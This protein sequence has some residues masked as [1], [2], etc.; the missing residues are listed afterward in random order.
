MNIVAGG[1]GSGQGLSSSQES[2]RNRVAGGGG[3]GSGLSS[4]QESKTEIRTTTVLFVEFSKG[5]TMQKKLRE[6]LDRITP[7]LGFRI[8][9]TEKGGTPLGSLLSNKNL[10]SGVECGRGTCR[11]CAQPDER[12][13]P[14]TLRNVVYESECRVCNPPGTRKEADKQGLEERRALA[15]LYVGESA[16][17][18][19]ERAAEHWRDAESGKEESHMLEHQ[20]ESH[21]GEGPPQFA[22]TVV[23][24]CKTSLERQVREAIR[25]Q[26]RGTVLNK[27]GVYNRCKQTR[28]EAKGDRGG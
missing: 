15:S 26:M 25:I 8:R 22:F 18:V 20:V 23:K 21:E 19:A 13:E 7:M 4:N 3:S 12:K 27:K 10:W 1:G 11:T 24:S 6:C 2:K 28:L 9:V 14:C 16:R 5:G 17:S